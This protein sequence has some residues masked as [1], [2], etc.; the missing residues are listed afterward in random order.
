[1]AIITDT[2]IL[3]LYND[4]AT[5]E[6]GFNLL[7]KKF[8]EPMYW[9]LRR[10]LVDHE[11]TN[12][13][14]QNVFIKIWQN[15]NKFR[16]DSKLY[17]WIYRIATNEAIS[18][19]KSSKAKYNISLD[20]ENENY[21]SNKLQDDAYFQA[22]EIEMKLQK[23]ILKLPQKQKMVFLLRYYKEMNYNQMSEVLNTNVNTLKATYHI[24]A[25]KVED[26]LK[27]N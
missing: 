11:D 2:E 7:V 26:F 15:L 25:K 5:K 1:M 19:L 4:P 8:S 6:K 17:T 13:V 21:I 9:H 16:E 27:E 23:A 14:M 10:I 24:A 3:Q 22:S 18:Y 12:D 20:A